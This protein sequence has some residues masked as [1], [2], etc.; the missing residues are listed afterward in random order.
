MSDEIMTMWDASNLPDPQ[1]TT[2]VAAF[3][4][5]GDTPHVYTDAQV[6]AIRARYGLPIWTCYDAANDGVVE[7][8]RALAWLHRR[9]WTRG[10]EVALDTEELVIPEFISQFNT[11]ITQSGYLVLHYESKSSDGGNPATSGG[12]WSA[13][14]TGIAHLRPGDVAT[15]YVPDSW[16]GEPYDL[17]VIVT[18]APL[19]QLTPL[20]THKILWGDV[21]VHVPVLQLGDTGPAV[22][23]MQHL[24]EAWYP[25]STGP[26]GADGM[27]GPVTLAGLVSFQR[28][29]GLPAAAGVCDS[30]T[31]RELLES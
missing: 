8:E 13:D 31:W 25:A 2:P 11:V 30:P 19:H 29:M 18:A 15:Q 23:R 16:L 22:A 21:S 28:A 24:L 6:A 1:P 20:V 5:G 14:W 10:T 4:I 7:A 17:S 12:R 26:S 9:N 27:F 3:Y